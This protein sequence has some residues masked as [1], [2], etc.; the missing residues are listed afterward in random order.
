[1]AAGQ[2]SPF[3]IPNPGTM[4]ITGTM[5]TISI[6]PVQR[7]AAKVAGLAYLIALVP[8]V[9]A[10]FYVRAH[11][12]DFENAVQTATNIISHERLFRLGIA[13]NLLVFAI[14]IVLIVSLYIVL[15]PVNRILAL[16][17]LAWGLIE[18]GILVIVT[19][20]DLDVLRLLS[21]VDYLQAFDRN[22]LY[23]MARVSISAHAS[24]YNIGL[25]FA[26]LRSTAFCFLWIRSDYVPK[27]LAAFGMLASLLMGA[28]ALLFVIF[29]GLSQVMSVGIYGGPIFIFELI[30]GFWLLLNKLRPAETLSQ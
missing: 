16:T 13:S 5:N 25:M 12:V 29:P 4:N 7:K 11:L 8:A 30:F 23:S 19:L 18:T 1:M 14:D 2:R 3:A 10:E 21:G 28:S 9:F 20:H 26:G 6:D 24:T 27:I 17:A 15:K 22:Q